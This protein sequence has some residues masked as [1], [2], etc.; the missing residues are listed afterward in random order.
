MLAAIA[1][2]LARSRVA[3]EGGAAEVVL[4]CFCAGCCLPCS[5]LFA[6]NTAVNKPARRPGP[7]QAGPTYGRSVTSCCEEQCLPLVWLAATLNPWAAGPV[8]RANIS[9]SCNQIGICASCLCLVLPPQRHPPLHA[10]AVPDSLP[11]HP[12][13]HAAG[14]S[15]GRTPAAV[16][17]RRTA[18]RRQAAAVAVRRRRRRREAGLKMKTM[19]TRRCSAS[20]GPCRRGGAQLRRRRSL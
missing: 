5:G 2:V 3:Q 7:S 15:R 9:S 20:A 10:S 17:R 13:L 19:K 8:L 11:A 6:D 12:A 4:A 16:R 14:A 1:A 18:T